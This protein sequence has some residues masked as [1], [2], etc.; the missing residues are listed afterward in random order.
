MR[1]EEQVDCMHQAIF[2]V[3]REYERTRWES[4]AQ[5]ME[6]LGA[7]RKF[8]GAACEKKFRAKAKGKKEG[9]SDVPTGDSKEVVADGDLLQ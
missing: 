7:S 3:Q 9:P 2:Q 6:E 4:V 8:T 1:C 5:R